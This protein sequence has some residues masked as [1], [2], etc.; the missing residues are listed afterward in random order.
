[1]K[2]Y[3][4][5]TTV[6]LISNFCFTQIKNNNPIRVQ[7]PKLKKINVPNITKPRV[8]EHW[9]NENQNYDK[10]RYSD[11]K[12]VKSIFEVKKNYYIKNGLLFYKNK[13][14]SNLKINYQLNDSVEYDLEIKKGKPIIQIVEVLGNP[15]PSMHRVEYTGDSVIYKFLK[16][17]SYLNKGD[18]NLKF[19]YYGKWNP[20]NQKF[21]TE[22]I[23]EEGE[24]KNNFKFGEWKY[25]DKKGEIVSAKTYTIQDSVDVRFPFS[26]FNKK[27]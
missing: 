2:K 6:L 17:T 11:F 25:Y 9:Y 24:V 23:K 27:E 22:Y 21:S 8:I 18:G 13:I 19:Y 5:T 4:I 10:S 16:N 7:P 15:K 26:I 14:V 20:K 3:F 12:K 1:M